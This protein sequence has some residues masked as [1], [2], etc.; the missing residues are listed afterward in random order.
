MAIL[1]EY[2]SQLLVD[3]V[4]LFCER[5]GHAD[6]TGVWE[7]T[8]RMVAAHNPNLAIAWQ[9]FENTMTGEEIV[10][11]M[12]GLIINILE[13]LPED[14]RTGFHLA[15]TVGRGRALGMTRQEA[16]ALHLES[17]EES[18]EESEKQERTPTLRVIEGGKQGQ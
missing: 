13:T 17:V 11:P 16:L 5:L 14:A 4:D 18:L 1:Q 15:F 10:I 12:Q 3:E 2:Q 7:Y 6:F 8:K 9:E